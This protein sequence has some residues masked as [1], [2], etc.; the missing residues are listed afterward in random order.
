[1]P[2]KRPS[3]SAV[4]DRWSHT[5]LSEDNGDPARPGTQRGSNLAP[6]SIH[7]SITDNLATHC[8]RQQTH[9]ALRHG[10]GLGYRAEEVY[11]LRCFT[12]EKITP[13]PTDTS[14]LR[15]KTPWSS[16]SFRTLL[17]VPELRDRSRG[18][19]Y[20]MDSVNVSVFIGKKPP[21]PSSERHTAEYGMKHRRSRLKTHT[22]VSA[23]CE[24]P[25]R[26]PLSPPALMLACETTPLF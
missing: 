21:L 14:C 6:F 3:R 18:C 10:Q 5:L 8:S 26:E 9:Q 7:T 16:C 15:H 11:E 1:M 19:L 17:H 12:G 13:T 20:S 24:L 23:V 25:L 2:L 22:I 4:L